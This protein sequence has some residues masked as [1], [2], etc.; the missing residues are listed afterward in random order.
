MHT[1]LLKKHYAAI[2]SDNLLTD[3]E[4]E[5]LTRVAKF[6]EARQAIGEERT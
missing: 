5:S 2:V 4:M 3:E 1:P 6:F